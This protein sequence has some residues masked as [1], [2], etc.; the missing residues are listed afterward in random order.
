MKIT[1]GKCGN[2]GGEVEV[3]EIWAGDPHYN[4]ATCKNCGAQADPIASM[5]TIKMMPQVTYVVNGLPVK[6]NIC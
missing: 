1:V 6:D 5:P 4:V 3:Y 2:C